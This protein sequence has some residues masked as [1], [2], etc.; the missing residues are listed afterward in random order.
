ME[1]LCFTRKNPLRKQAN[2]CR[3]KANQAKPSGRQGFTYPRHRRLL[4]GDWWTL[5]QRNL[6]LE[7]PLRKHD[8]RSAAWF[9]EESS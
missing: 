5:S 7:V 1:V 8:S 9:A 6:K 4:G 2:A 3:I